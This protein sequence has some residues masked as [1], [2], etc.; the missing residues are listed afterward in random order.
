MSYLPR[1]CRPAP[2]S[3]WKTNCVKLMG[4]NLSLLVPL[5]EKIHDS[6]FLNPRIV[7][8]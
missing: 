3:D 1:L 4:H 7:A 5:S 8:S 2:G 6:L